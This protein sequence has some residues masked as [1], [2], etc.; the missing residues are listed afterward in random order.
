MRCQ[1]GA[2]VYTGKASCTIIRIHGPFAF[3]T[4]SASRRL[5]L[6]REVF[7]YVPSGRLVIGPE[8]DRARDFIVTEST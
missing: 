4:T 7:R 6:Q 2:W 3:P 8:T 1:H 5:F